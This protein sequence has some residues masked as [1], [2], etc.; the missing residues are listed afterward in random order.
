V[1]GDR[2]WW[3][4]DAP[5]LYLRAVRLEAELSVAAALLELR[6]KDRQ[7]EIVAG[8]LTKW[9]DLIAETPARQAEVM[10][11]FMPPVQGGHAA[12]GELMEA[13]ARQ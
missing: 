1:S 4:A 12:E 2:K 6:Q 10:K 7:S 9:R 5:D 8:L 13:E 3:S 11:P